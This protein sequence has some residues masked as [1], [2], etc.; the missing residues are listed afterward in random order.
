MRY[1]KLTIIGFCVFTYCATQQ[2]LIRPGYDFSK[3][4][5]IKV[6]D[7]NDFPYAEG[8]GNIIFSALSDYLM[9]LGLTVVEGQNPSDAIMVCSISDFTDQRAVYIP[10]EI[11]DKGTSTEKAYAASDYSGS[12]TSEKDTSIKGSVK[13]TKEIR[14]IDAAVGL[15]LQLL[16]VH[17]SVAIWSSDFTYSALNQKDALNKCIDGA[18]RPLKRLLKK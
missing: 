12:T 1:L 9:D 5:A 8:S 16:D 13:R 18:L 4:K 14:Y 7:I 3:V 2:P 17:K 15:K 11:V 10:I 6:Q